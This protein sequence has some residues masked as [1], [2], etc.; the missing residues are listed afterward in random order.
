MKKMI[1]ILGAMLMILSSAAALSVNADERMTDEEANVYLEVNKEDYYLGDDN[2][3]Y[4]STN[5]DFP[6]NEA[7]VPAGEY[8][9]TELLKALSVRYPEG[10]FA[11]WFMGSINPEQMEQ[12]IERLKQE[13]I[14]AQ[15]IDY[16]RMLYAAMTAEQ[17]E[18][19]PANSEYYEFGYKMGLAPDPITIKPTEPETTE[20]DTTVYGD[21]SGDGVV[22][23]MDVIM[24]NKFLLGNIALT[25][26]QKKAGDCNRDGVFDST[27][28]LDLLKLVVEL[29]L[30]YEF[31]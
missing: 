9:R 29:P 18:N 15:K 14:E 16:P 27:D 2:I 6:V 23:I 1:A 20:P 10:K 24:F 3:Y 5:E 8:E 11:V 30:G 19:F 17:L 21:V 12:D 4:A 7:E 22:D 25:D 13:G 31:S 26:Q 28:S